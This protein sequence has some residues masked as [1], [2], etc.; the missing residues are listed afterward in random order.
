VASSRGGTSPDGAVARR[1][2]DT[3]STAPN[4]IEDDRRSDR[5]RFDV[6]DAD[7][8]KEI[9]F[10]SRIAG[11]QGAINAQDTED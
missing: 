8:A 3:N 4:S 10:G 6:S 9:R 5:G 2:T 7:P 1:D 11:W